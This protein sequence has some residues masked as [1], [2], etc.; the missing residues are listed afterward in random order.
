MKS[1]F[2]LNFTFLRGNL[3]TRTPQIVSINSSSCFSGDLDLIIIH[4]EQVIRTIQTNQF[5]V[6]SK[7]NSTMQNTRKFFYYNSGNR[8]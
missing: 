4:M 8:G 3:S 2:Q 7:Y 6:H 1:I 5:D